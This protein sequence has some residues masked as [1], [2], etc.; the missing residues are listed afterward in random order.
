MTLHPGPWPAGAPAWA[1]LVVPDLDAARAF[2]AAVLGW[3]YLAEP[4]PGG[5]ATY[6]TATV[7]G[8]RGRG[9]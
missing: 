7:G 2:Y 3:E 5:G 8:Y 9:R 4:A 6:L 1:D